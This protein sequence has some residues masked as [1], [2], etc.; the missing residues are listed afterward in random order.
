MTMRTYTK[1]PGD[2]EEMKSLYYI[3]TIEDLLVFL[4]SPLYDINFF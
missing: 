3:P 2:R 1:Y 4:V